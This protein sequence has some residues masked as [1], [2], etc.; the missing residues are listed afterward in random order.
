MLVRPIL[1]ISGLLFLFASHALPQLASAAN[2]KFPVDLKVEA[3]TPL[4]AYITHRVSYRIGDAVEAKLIEPIWAYDRIV[5]P[6]GATLQGRVV[7]LDPVPKMLRARAIVGGDFTPLKRAKVSFLKL[8][9]PDGRSMP[10]QTQECYGLAT[11]YVQPRLPKKPKN[12]KASSGK[13]SRMRQFLLRQAENQA[14]ARSQ[15]VYGLVRGPNKK[16]WVENFLLSKLPY[17]PQW[18]QARTRFDA[19]LTAPLDF[20]TAE[21]ASSEIASSGTPTRP[22]SIGEMT[23]LDTISSADAKVGDPMQGVLSKPLFTPEHKLLLPQGT[24]LTGR[25]TLTQ[26]ARMFHRGGKLR[27][28]IDEIQA[29]EEASALG[30]AVHTERPV[31][32]DAQLAAAEADP[33]AVKVDSEGTATAKESKTRL[34]RPAIA[35]LVAVKTLD[36]DAGKQTAS[37]GGSSNVGGRSLG[38]FSGFGLFG[39][40]ASR[41]G[42]AAVGEALGFY[43]LAWSAYSTVVS[44]GKDVTFEKNTALAIRFGNPPEK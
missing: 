30:N 25:I 18:Y 34:L 26:R 44:R 16:E 38:G 1:T 32:T 40:A 12:Q 37:G 8:A 22:D 42:P 13:S 27:F 36:E 35:G 17:H 24:R 28:A 29:P 39:T 33:K 23:L 4:R 19:V 5:I 3:G 15:G 20:G 2:S 9:L 31:K 41:W 10:L 14:N 6:A 21:V 43:G 11:I 7:E